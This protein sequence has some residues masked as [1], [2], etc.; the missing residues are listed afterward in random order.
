MRL[1]I[2]PA[3][4]GSSRIKDK[5]IHPMLGRPM[6]AYPL[7]AAAATGLFDEI[8]VSTDSPKY[9]EIAKSLGFPTPFLR[10][11][12]LAANDSGLLDMLRWTVAQY[13]KLG[14]TVN[15]ICMIYSTAVLLDKTDIAQGIEIFEQYDK[16]LPVLSVATF[17]A[18]IERAFIVD[19]DSV[20]KWAWPEHR[21]RHSQDC[22]PHYY[23]MAGYLIMTREFLFASKE[24]VPSKFF[25]SIIPRWKAIDI[26]DP[27]D[28]E[29]A[30]RLMRGSE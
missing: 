13:E 8:H 7:G 12:S 27:E 26:N 3:R 22:V 18:P 16:A 29:V 28:L 15:D 23:D 30:E 24:A 5:N 21:D 2:L 17:P 6:M 14:R 4:S 1:A 11:T 25:P 19:N 10:D 20:L 9:A